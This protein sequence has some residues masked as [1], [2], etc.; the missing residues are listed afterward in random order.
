[1]SDAVSVMDG[2]SFEGLVQVREAG[3]QGMITL[4]GDLASGAVASAVKEAAGCAIPAL[5]RMETAGGNA[6]LWMSPDE[7]LVL[8]PYDDAAACAARMQQALSAEHALVANVS[9][10]RA[11]FALSGADAP[12]RE[13]LAKL[14]PVDM[15]PGA[16]TPG[17]VRRTR[18][19]QVAAAFWM[20]AE[21]QAR[22][23]CFRSVGQYMFDLLR[24]AAA[25]GSAVNHF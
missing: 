11:F 5:R 10:A 4:R 14:A 3:L 13:V 15:A 17:M 19:A 16:F 21:G 2:A 20:P 9:D 25:P 6:A 22:V 12:L 23:V 24:T 18:L 7:L 1:M 8:V